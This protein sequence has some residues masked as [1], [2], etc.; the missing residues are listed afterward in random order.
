MSF[1]NQTQIMNRAELI[2]QTA[3]AVNRT[4]LSIDATLSALLNT[5]RIALSDGESIK[6]AEFGTLKVV[7]RKERVGVDPRNGQRI[8]IPEHNTVVFIPSDKLKALVNEEV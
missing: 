8:C 5:A 7:F 6:L 1:T 3:A 2:A 4:N